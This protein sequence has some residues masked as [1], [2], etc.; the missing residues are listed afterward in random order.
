[1][2]V[3]AA[4]QHGSETLVRRCEMC[5]DPARRPVRRRRARNVWLCPRHFDDWI[6]LRDNRS[7]WLCARHF[8]LALRLRRSRLLRTIGAASRLRGAR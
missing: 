3:N 2:Q 8:E 6:D 1:M 4:A 7:I 5:D